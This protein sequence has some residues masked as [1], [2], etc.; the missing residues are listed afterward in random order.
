[1]NFE[2]QDLEK[3]EKLW[4]NASEEKKEDLEVGLG[5]KESETLSFLLN[6]AE[7]T[8]DS[9]DAEILSSEEIAERIH[10]LLEM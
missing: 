1:M 2:N 4:K 6:D 9:P 10:A 7:M 3:V 5:I 8:S